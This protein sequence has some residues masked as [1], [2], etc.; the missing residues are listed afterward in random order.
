[1]SN[2]IKCPSCGTVFEPT[3][4]IRDQV[5][6]ELRSKAADWQKKKNEEYQARLEEEKKK[7][8]QAMEENLRRSIAGDFEVKLKMLEESKRDAEEKLKSSRQKELEFLKMEQELKTRTEELDLTVQKRLQEE[9]EKL[10]LELRKLEEQKM[11]TRDQEYQLKLKELEKQLEDQKKLAE[12]MRR[13]AEQGSMQLQGEV[14]E[15]ALEKMLQEAFPQDSVD[16]VR[17]G[18][19][20][21][22]TVRNAKAEECGKIIFESKRTKGWQNVWVEKLKTDMRKEQADLAIL[23]SQVYPRGMECFGERE[24]VWIA[25]FKEVLHLTMA[26]RNALIRISEVRQSEENREGKMQMLYDYLTGVDFRQKMETIVEGFTAMR[27]SI[28]RERMQMEK[29]WKEREKQLEKVLIGTSGL[30]GSIRGI[31][32][33]S[34]QEIPLLELDTPSEEQE[35]DAA[36]KD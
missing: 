3:E 1:M 21:V 34:V 8:A 36:P 2:D 28:T 15:L 13:K 6:K 32:G 9:R 18:A 17:K 27:N 26:L 7:M 30:Y 35:G 5:E 33:A 14:A 16:E 10:S 20:C 25:S 23:V 24:G 19:D 31:A 22:L 12:E 4:A 29:L 11:A